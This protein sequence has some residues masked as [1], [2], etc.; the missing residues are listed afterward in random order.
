M[1]IID[2]KTLPLT[3]TI[4]IKYILLSCTALY[5]VYCI[6]FVLYCILLRIVLY[7]FD[8]ILHVYNTTV[9]YV[10]IVYNMTQ[11]ITI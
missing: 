4:Y 6:V 11:H 1:F 7:F 3:Y 8:T 5:I 2:Y 10:Y 9:R